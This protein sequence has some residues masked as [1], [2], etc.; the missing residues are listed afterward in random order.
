MIFQNGKSEDLVLE[1]FGLFAG[2]G[3]IGVKLE[4][5]LK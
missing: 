4:A 5:A 3:S 2:K 1:K